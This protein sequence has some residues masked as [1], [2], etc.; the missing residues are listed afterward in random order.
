M[1]FYLGTHKACWLE[2]LEVPLFLSDRELR[3]HKKLPRAIDRWALDSAGFTE[4]DKFHGWRSKP[5]EYARRVRRYHDEIGGLDFA[6]I[7]DWMCEESMLEK[8][9]FPV[10]EHI[11][12]TVQSYLDLCELEPDLPWLP[13]LQGWTLGDY[14]DCLELYDKRG[15]DLRGAWRVGIGTMC[16]RQETDTAGRIL[17][18]LASLGLNL[19]A[20]GFHKEGVANVGQ[21]I[22]SSDSFSWSMNAY[23]NAGKWFPDHTQPGPGR[24]TGHKTCSNCPEYA[25]RWRDE[26]L[27]T[28]PQEPTPLDVMWGLPL[29]DPFPLPQAA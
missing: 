12:R 10:H 1:I 4:L 8:T 13:T 18:H 21:V 6:G 3:K 15:V 24:R 25:L 28:I 17:R 14:L 22:H 26:L 9:R 29:P 2:R 20:Y 19:H 27:A 7:Q 23:R 11:W 5:R 16:K